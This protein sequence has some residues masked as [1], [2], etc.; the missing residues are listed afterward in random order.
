MRTVSSLL[1]DR[2][3]C[4]CL[5]MTYVCM[6]VLVGFYQVDLAMR[7]FVC[8]IKTHMLP[9]QPIYNVDSTITC[10]LGFSSFSVISDI[11]TVMIQCMYI[12]ST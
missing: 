2:Y 12:V 1:W 7:S 6:C 5:C 11:Q 9:R 3:G 10:Q 4:E 8:S